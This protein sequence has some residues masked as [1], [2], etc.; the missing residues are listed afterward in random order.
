MKHQELSK[1]HIVIIFALIGIPWLGLGYNKVEFPFFVKNHF[2]VK[3]DLST[4]VGTIMA[5]E[6]PI[7]AILGLFVGTIYDYYGRRGPILVFVFII[8]LNMI[9]TPINTSLFPG[10]V[11]IQIISHLS[12]TCVMSSPL[13]ADLVDPSSLS[14]VAHFQSVFVKIA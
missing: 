10:A 2:G 4:V 7:T 6:Y 5:I 14:K 11:I 9:M 1:I 8:S 13:V 3:E 12:I